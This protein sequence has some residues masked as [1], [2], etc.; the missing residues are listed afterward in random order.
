MKGQF[1]TILI[2][3]TTNQSLFSQVKQLLIDDVAV[4]T[5]RLQGYPDWIE[6]DK[7]S[8]WISNDGLMQRIN[9]VTNAVVAEV[10]ISKPCAAFTIGFGSVWVASCGDK[11]IARIGLDSN[12]VVASA[13]S[14]GERPSTLICARLML[15]MMLMWGNNS[16]FWNTMPMRE[17]SFGRSVPAPPTEMPSTTTSPC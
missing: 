4:G 8:V 2:L 3:L 9:P 12:L 14:A 5:I 6:I 17:R 15:S 16:K 7:S 11:T 10:K 13:A 1:L